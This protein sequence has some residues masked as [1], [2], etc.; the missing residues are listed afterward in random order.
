IRT[1]TRT[2]TPTGPTA[3]RTNTPNGP[4]ATRTNTPI[5]LTATRTNTPT[6]LTATRTATPGA[7]TC[8][9]ITGGGSFAISTTATCF[10]YV[11][12]AFVRGGMFT[13]MNGSTSA[14]NTLNWYGGRS[15]SVTSCI[16]DSQI[17]NG[18]GAQLNNFTVAKDSTSAMYLTITG[19]AA[20]TV[21]ISIQNWMNGT[22]CSVAPTPLGPPGPTNTP[23]PATATRTNTPVGP[24]ATRTNTPVGPTATR[25]N[26]PVGPTN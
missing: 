16:N 17:L 5:V 10:K 24:T 2:N 1:A 22:G 11:N 7:G 8:T 3:T 18:N 14:A 4:T 21:S 19:N 13:V 20:N 9:T 23:A 6:V 12:T 25:T 15:E 26:T